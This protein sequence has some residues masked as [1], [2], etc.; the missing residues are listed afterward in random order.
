MNDTEVKKYYPTEKKI[1]VADKEFIA[2]P[3]CLDEILSMWDDL[4]KVIFQVVDS[5]PQLDPKKIDAKDIYILSPV[6]REVTNIL[7]KFLGCDIVWLKENLYPKELITLV[8]EFIEVNDVGGI[9]ENFQLAKSKFQ[10]LQTSKT[11]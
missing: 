10:N 11:S 4:A 3:F 5:N 1:K 2:H 9:L 6:M 7:S 8:I